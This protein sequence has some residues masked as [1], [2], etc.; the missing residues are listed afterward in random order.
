MDARWGGRDGMRGSYMAA[1]DVGSV[2]NLL[3]I[4]TTTLL[5]S[6]ARRRIECNPDISDSLET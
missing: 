2:L 3:P 6:S 4:M 5:A 1:M